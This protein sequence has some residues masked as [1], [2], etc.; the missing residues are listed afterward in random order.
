MLR[1]KEIKFHVTPKVRQSGRYYGIVAP[2]MILIGLTVIAIGVGI[3]RYLDAP[4]GEAIGLLAVNAFWATC[5]AIALSVLVRAAFWRPSD[6]EE[7]PAADAAQPE[8]SK[9]LSSVPT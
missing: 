1:G 3:S 2:H 9:T 8:P 5:N 7:M 6:D 4:S